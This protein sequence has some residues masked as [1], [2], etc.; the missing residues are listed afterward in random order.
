MSTGRRLYQRRC[1]RLGR[2]TAARAEERESLLQAD[3]RAPSLPHEQAPGE[4]HDAG[5]RLS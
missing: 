4:G 1:V 3:V 2:A 5:E